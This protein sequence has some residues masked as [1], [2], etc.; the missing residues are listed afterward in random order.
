MQ[1]LRSAAVATR[2]AART[3]SER[4]LLAIR[5]ADW[6]I[7]KRG[8]RIVKA[9]LRTSIETAATAAAAHYSTG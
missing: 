2:T 4:E 8:E 7:A 5:K 9:A 3:T 1:L 6:A